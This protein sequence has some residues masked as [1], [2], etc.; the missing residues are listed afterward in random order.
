MVIPM[1]KKNKNGWIR[2]VEAVIAVIIVFA[3]VLIVISK[4]NADTQEDDKCGS[5]NQYLNEIAKSEEMRYAVMT[6]NST[7]VKDYLIKR[8]D[9]PSVENQ[10]S[11]C[12]PEDA[13]PE[14]NSISEKIDIC[15]GERIITGAKNADPNEYTPRK[16]KV[17][18]YRRS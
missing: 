3:S 11:I 17:F 6:E 4:N 12:A 8:I 16:V 14:K 7:A 1:L 10:V 9:N 2:I 15:V 18:V 5:L 13:C